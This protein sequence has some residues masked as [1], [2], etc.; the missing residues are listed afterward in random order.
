VSQQTEGPAPPGDRSE[1]PA[2]AKPLDASSLAN[3][4]RD[5]LE[6]AIRN[7]AS[8]WWHS[9]AILAIRQLALSGRGFDIDH[10]RDMAGEP[11]DPHY[12]GALFAAAQKLKIIEAVG[13]RV[14]RDGK[15]RRIWWGVPQ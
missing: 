4:E 14:G 7:S 2:A 8:D 6:Q 15:L 10:I 1:S 5:G 13:A 12:W 3:S 11:E 9:G